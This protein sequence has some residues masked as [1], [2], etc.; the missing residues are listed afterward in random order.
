MSS[1]GMQHIAGGTLYPY[2]STIPFRDLREEPQSGR[3]PTLLF[4]FVR[5]LLKLRADTPARE[6]FL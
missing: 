4:T 2:D 3:E 1:P 5:A 6:P